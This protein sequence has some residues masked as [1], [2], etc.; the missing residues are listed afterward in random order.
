M[1]FQQAPAPGTVTT[2]TATGPGT[3]TVPANTAYL[4]VE[5]I[6]GGGAGAGMTTAGV[7]AGAG[8][9]EYAAEAVF[10]ASAGQVIPYVVGAGDTAG[11]SPAGGQATVFGPAPGG[12]LQVLANGGGSVAT[13]SNVAGLGGSGSGNSVEHPGGPG[14][15]QPGVHVRRRRRLERRRPVR[16]QHP[17]GLRVGAVHH[18]RDATANGWTCPAGVFQVTRR[19]L[20]RRRRRRRP[21]ARRAT[22]QGGGGGEYRKPA[23]RASRRATSTPVVVGRGRHGRHQRRATG[24]TAGSRASP[25]TASPVI[26]K[27]GGL[28]LGNSTSDAVQRRYGRRGD[29]RLQRRPG[30]R[31]L[32][33]HGR[34]RVLGRARARRATRAAAPAGRSPRP[35]RQR[36]Q[37]VRAEQRRGLGGVGSR[38]RRRRVVQLQLV[39]GRGGCGRAG[40]AHLPGDHGSAYERA[41]ARRSTR[42]AR[43]ATAAPQRALRAPRVRA[44]GGGGRRR[45]LRRAPP[46]RAARARTGSSRSPRSR[47]RPSRA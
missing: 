27:G 35:G 2:V 25:G 17:D 10:P 41:A 1:S 18:G 38:R 33:V 29:Y 5:A 43:A 13:N 28:G 14:P 34:R 19:M 11:A 39:R 44:P 46:S 15:R 22:A 47:P 12:T 6:G 23:G 9:A 36:R 7:G 42:E 21:A 45:V 30:R 26:G 32:P 24:R 16:G 20:G 37:R 40:A 8:G 3:Y 31:R 4:K